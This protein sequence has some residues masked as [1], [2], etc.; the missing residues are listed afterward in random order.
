MPVKQKDLEKRKQHE[1]DQPIIDALSQIDLGT[2]SLM[3]LLQFGGGLVLKHA[4]AAEITEYLGRSRYE[5]SEEFKGYRNGYQSTNFDTPLGQFKYDRPKVADAPDFKSKFHRPG[6]RRPEEFADSI[7]DMFINGVSTRKVKDSLRAV[8]GDKV[9]LSRSS[10]SR[11]TKRMRSEF[12]TW[13]SRPLSEVKVAYLFLDAIRV[14]MRM[15]GTSK[16]AVL[17]AYAILED[18]TMEL[19][20]IDIGHSESDRSWGKFVERLKA[21]GLNDPL[22]VCSDGNQG[23]INAIDTHFTTSYR[24]RCLKHREQNILDAVPKEEQ[25]PVAK[26]LKAIFYGATSL[27]QA[28]QFVAAFKRDF[29]KTYSTAVDRLYADL[30]QCLVFY[31]F[32]HHHWKRMRT[33]NKLE[34]LNRELRRRLDVIGRHPDE[35]GCLSLI[36]A[37]TTKYAANQNGF[38]VD[39]LTKKMWTELRDK[40]V[41]MIAQLELDLWAA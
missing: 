23:V 30:D 15:G 33:S 18:R 31:M 25:G 24:Q 12:A 22:L 40:K 5:R 13:K 9:R 20:A 27:S 8:A 17:L 3:S 34:R 37:V 28:K 41:E 39:D 6:M 32:P 16:D 29:Q 2:T 7:T 1:V 10:V 11:I 14:G 19:L 36:Y 38:K 21:R 4:V 26:A 35:D